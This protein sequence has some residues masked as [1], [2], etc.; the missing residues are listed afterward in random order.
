MAAPPMS[1]QDSTDQ[2]GSKALHQGFGDQ[3]SSRDAV[4]TMTG[5]KRGGD[6]RCS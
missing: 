3:T 2:Y 4:T 1:W 5:T 6:T